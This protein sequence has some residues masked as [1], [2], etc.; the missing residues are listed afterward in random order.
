MALLVRSWNLFHG[1]AK[2]PQ[3]AGFLAEMVR[4]ASAD[5]PDVLCLQEVPVWAL[6]RLGEWS[7]MTVFAEVA[8]RP[9]LGPLPAPAGLAR[10]VTALHHG[11]IRSAFTGQGNAILLTPGARPLAHGSLV[12]N[13]RRFRRIEERRLGLG[14]V[15]RLAWAKERRVCHAVRARFPD[16]STALVSTLHA[17]SFPADER[18]ADAEVLR[19][20]VFSD[21]LA[22]PDE[23]CV[24]AGDLNVWPERSRTLA[25]LSGPEWGF[26]Q[27][28]AGIDQILVRGGE[29][30]VERWPRERRVVDGVLLSDHAPVEARIG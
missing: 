27:P 29:G 16:G 22:E 21:G 2:P 4:L 15:A 1:N 23:L 20:A 11:V 17:T 19:A 7:G 13:E 9:T 30:R 3:R 18:L 6:E 25:E 24:I 26:S 28:Q 5:R 14:L 10:A 12:L 8:T